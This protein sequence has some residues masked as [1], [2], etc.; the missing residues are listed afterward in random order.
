MKRTGNLYNSIVSIENLVK[1]N[2]KAGRGKGNTKDV[3]FFDENRGCNIIDLHNILV[4]NLYN[5]SEYENFTIFEP[6]ERRISKLPFVDRI[7]HH[8]ILNKIEPLFIDSFISQT[9]SCIKRRGIHKCINDF[10]KRLKS[11]TYCLKIDIK[12]FYPSVNNNIL[13]AQLRTKFKDFKLLNLLDNIVDSF[14][15]LPLGNVTSQVFGNFYLNNFDHW[16]KETMKVKDYFRY[17]D[18][19]IILSNNKKDLHKLRINI[20]EFL[21]VN[22][23]LELS[24]YKVIPIS[25]GIDFLGYVSYGTHIKIRKSIKIAFKRMLIKYPNSASI[26]SYMGWLKHCNSKNL[27]N[28]YGKETGIN[29]RTS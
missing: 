4:N 27:I 19:S 24:K 6:K 25:T 11:N 7:V 10:N 2:K 13:K 5:T 17:C 8:A 12:K 9:Y 1:A 20:Q 3:L 14:E 16:L 18:D 21:K 28:S 23:N 22:L 26:N 29:L 15:G